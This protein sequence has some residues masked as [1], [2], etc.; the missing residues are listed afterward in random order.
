MAT[1]TELDA[2]IEEKRRQIERYQARKRAL[3]AKERAQQRKWRAS[4]LEGIGRSVLDAAGCEW[5]RVDLEALRLWLAAHADE[6]QSQV[7]LAESSPRDAKERLD[8]L[9]GVQ[10]ETATATDS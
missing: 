2:K 3:V 4:V 8:H 10:R 1:I 6:L 7:V 5:S 9:K